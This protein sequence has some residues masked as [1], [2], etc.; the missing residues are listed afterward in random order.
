[1]AR[2]P[3]AICTAYWVG[4]YEVYNALIIPR[5]ISAACSGLSDGGDNENWKS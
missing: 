4:K 1:M 3:I 5:T 2:I